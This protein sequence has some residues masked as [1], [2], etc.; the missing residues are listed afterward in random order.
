MF[1]NSISPFVC[2]SCLRQ[3][4]SALQRGGSSFIH[5]QARRNAT[6]A[7]SRGSLTH[8]PRGASSTTSF[9]TISRSS[10]ALNQPRTRSSGS[11]ISS[12]SPDSAATKN[13]NATEEVEEKSVSTKPIKV[14]SSMFAYH[15]E[16]SEPTPSA[17]SDADDFFTR[18]KPEML[19]TIGTFRETPKSSAPEV[20]F[21]GRSNVGKSSLLNAILGRKLCYTSSKPGRTRTMNAI[22]VNDG[23]LTVLDMPGYGKGSHE[24]WG[25][26]IMKYLIGRKQLRRVFLLLDPEHGPKAG[27]IQLLKALRY[28]AIPHQIVLSKTDKL[29]RPRGRNLFTKVPGDRMEML[30]Q[31]FQE[32][33]KVVQ[34]RRRDGPPAL[35]EIIACSAE[36]GL[37][38]KNSVNAKLGIDRV[39]Y[40][41]LA[42][43]GLVG[44]RMAKEDLMSA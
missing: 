14:E 39:R 32:L 12:R 22:S 34:P 19:W 38:K 40:A 21:L 44:K 41:I 10:S 43:T 29:V 7:A 6:P 42:A 24:E 37:E 35:G 30:K 27:D 8:I 33:R 17:L 15:W 3:Q 23:R 16:T 4:Q 2:R 36:K 9:S 18:R 25:K 31:V 5:L 13:P 28:H 1:F 11:R 26:E 20:A